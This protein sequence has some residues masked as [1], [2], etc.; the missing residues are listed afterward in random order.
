MFQDLLSRSGLSLD[1]LRNFVAFAEA[2]SIVKASGGDL[3]R[4][5]LMS[6]QLRELE[7]FF[8]TELVARK[9]RGLV[10]TEPGRQLAAI[11]RQS[12]NAFGDFAATSRNRPIQLSLVAP[13]SVS[14]WLILPRLKR[15]A[16]LRPAVTWQ[17][18]H[19]STRDIVLGVQE[20]S[21]DF[22]FAPEDYLTPAVQKSVLGELD[23]LLFVP[24]AL[25]RSG[26]FSAE[27][28]MS[29]LP[30]AL[31]IGG[32]LRETVNK[33]AARQRRRLNVV[34]DCTSYLQAARLVREGSHA[35]LLPSLAHSEFEGLKAPPRTFPV[36]GLKPRRLCMIWS[37]RTLALRAA[38]EAVR[39]V[40]EKELKFA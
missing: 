16:R 25:A 33:T 11:A 28:A 9:G 23:Y 19:E 27:T 18:H 1:R 7:E 26:T 39:V 24:A 15:L 32:A 38:L 22:G 31:P 13:N 10:L 35:A 40:L 12:F 17:F 3:A 20:G 4:Q 5:A 6:R 2:G 8:E 21:Y 36:P 29:S 30:L 34:V 14:Q 37:A